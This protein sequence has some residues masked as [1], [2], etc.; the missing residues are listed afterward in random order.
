VERTLE[1]ID[2]A[3]AVYSRALED[4]VGHHLVGPPSKRVYRP[5]N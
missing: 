1:A 4:G 3:C 5:F 2:G